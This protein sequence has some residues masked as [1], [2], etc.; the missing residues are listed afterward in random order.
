VELQANISAAA[1]LSLSRYPLL[2]NY[3]IAKGTYDFGASDLHVCNA[4]GLT[5]TAEGAARL[6]F[7]PGFGLHV[8]NSSHG[9][10]DGLRV[11]YDPPPFAQVV[12]QD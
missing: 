5:V 2:T 1:S 7:Y 6:V 12:T 9:R 11:A 10:L 3:A 4:K 8:C